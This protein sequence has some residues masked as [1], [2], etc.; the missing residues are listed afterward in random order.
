MKRSL[1]DII[2]NPFIVLLGIFLVTVLVYANTLFNGFVID[3]QLFIVDWPMIQNLSNWPQFFGSNSQPVGEEGVY[4]PLKTTFHAINFFLWGSKPFGYHLIA[5]I[6]H[7]TGILFVYKIAAL[8][9]KN[10][11]V[12]AVCAVMFALHPVNVEAITFLTASID[13]L[14]VVFLFISFYFFLKFILTE[15]SAKNEYFLSCL[16]GLLA[17]FT[18]ELT[19]TLPLLFL[20]ASLCFSKKERNLRAHFI[21][22]LPFILITI[23][24]VVLKA[25]LLDGVNR[26]GYLYDSGYL[27]FL[28][29]IKALAKYVSIIFFPLNLSIDHMLSPGIFS[30][31]MQYFNK[32]AVLNQSLLDTQVVISLM[33]TLVIVVGAVI[34]WR[35]D[36]IIAFC[37]GWFY[38]SLL[39]VMNIIPTGSYFAERYLYLALFGFCFLIPYLA[40]SIF[41]QED[42]QSQAFLRWIYLIIFLVGIGFYGYR[43]Y[44]RNADWKNELT[45]YKAEVLNNPQHPTMRRDLG[46]TLLREEQP[47]RAIFHLRNVVLLRPNDADAYFAIAEAYSE[48]SKYQRAIRNYKKA[49]KIDPNFAE[50]YYNLAGIYASLGDHQKAKINLDKA[51]EEYKKSGRDTEAHRAFD[52]FREYFGKINGIVK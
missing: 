10:S 52:A 51:I 38:I 5:L 22:I 33:V 27:T 39:P 4:S 8:L 1:S 43:T 20:F 16:F 40:V 26:G 42:A 44:V 14:G 35:K 11:I 49:I 46:V 13:S 45:F 48:L 7:L 25:L 47:R 12:A 29:M 50:S 9:S 41:E 31:D 28:V 6:I 34:A 21:A 3:D 17:I 37:I 36:K 23:I 24:Y 2:T 15:K 18:H 19:I 32:N 30:V